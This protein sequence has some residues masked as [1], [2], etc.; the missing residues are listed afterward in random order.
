MRGKVPFALIG[1]LC[2]AM[3][4]DQFF[5]AHEARSVFL[6]QA[7]VIEKYPRIRY[8][9][10]SRWNE[11]PGPV[12]NKYRVDHQ[13]VAHLQNGRWF[14]INPRDNGVLYNGDS[15]RIE[16]AP[17]TGR[18]LHYQRMARGRSN[19]RTTMDAFEDIAPFPV[20]IAALCAWLLFFRTR[21][22]TAYNLRMAVIVISTCFLVCLIVI[23]WPT[24]RLLF[25]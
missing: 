18:V 3:I 9:R 10:W 24:I 23:S 19:V 15:V 1:A 8:R 25:G 21:E 22:T 13:Y 12:W 6:D 14:Q 20:L 7:T 17:L 16:V 2:M 4:V 11:T 5:F